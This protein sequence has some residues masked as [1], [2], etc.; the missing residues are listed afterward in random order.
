MDTSCQR[1]DSPSLQAPK[2]FLWT[3]E[4]IYHPHTHTHTHNDSNKHTRAFIVKPRG[5]PAALRRRAFP[6]AT[7]ATA[8]GRLTSAVSAE[9]RPLRCC[10]LR[11]CD[12]Q[13]KAVW[14]TTTPHKYQLHTPA[15]LF[16]PFRGPVWY[17]V[18]QLS[19]VFATVTAPVQANEALPDRLLPCVDRLLKP[20][21]ALGDPRDASVPPSASSVPFSQT[22]AEPAWC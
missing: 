2:F 5:T 10:G 11:T 3:E 7:I 1:S 22:E 12:P 19:F 4:P 17:P 8:R 20:P 6:S 14:P 13:P 21:L 16:I 9:I 15:P 18:T